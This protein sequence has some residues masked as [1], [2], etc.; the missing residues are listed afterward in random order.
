M[1]KHTKKLIIPC[2]A[3]ALT[4]GTSMVS[5]AASGWQQEDGTWRYY[6]R[7]GDEVTS[8]WK[9]SGNDWFWL[10]EDGEMAVSQLVEDDGNYYY[11]NE[12]GAM[13][14]NQWR[15]LDNEDPRDDED[16]DMVWYYFGPNGK[17]YKSNDSGRVNFKSI[18][19]AD[20]VTKKYAFDAEGKM[21]F[22][23]IDEQGERQIGD[24]AWQTGLYYLGGADDGAMRSSQWERLD[25]ADDEQTSDDFEDWYWFYFNAN[26][27]K[28][29]DTKKTINGR[30]YYFEEHGNTRF[31]WYATASNAS[32]ASPSSSYY[33]PIRDSWMSVGWFKTV[34]GENTD[35]EGYAD[36]EERWYYAEKD[37]EVVKSQIKKINGYYYAFDEYGKMLEGLYK[38]EVSGKEILSCEE[39]ESEDD[40][41]EAGDAAEV[42]Y[43]EGAGKAGAMKTGTA[44]VNIDGERYTYNFRKSGDECGQG[45]NGIQDGVIYEKGKRIEADSDE[46]YKKVEWNDPEDDTKSGT[47]LVNTTGKIQKGKKNAK[48]GDDRYYCTDSQ[49]FIT[50]EGTEKNTEK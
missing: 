39:I 2:A 8:A 4:L 48:D 36:G 11:V 25:V 23:W 46:K 20:G 19:R 7:N 26:G 43:F 33:S 40:L 42:Y 3:A 5:F 35:P 9:K 32:L 37:G 22:G 18:V 12:G 30:K 49:G 13:V 21:L 24:D 38:L 34:P 6:D 16:S 44:T 17:A 10:N 29:A 41:P 15:Q 27:K 1:K 31:D 28:A 14:T 45:Y 50:Y 47:Y